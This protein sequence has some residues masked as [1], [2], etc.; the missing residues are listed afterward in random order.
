MTATEVEAEVE[1]EIEAGRRRYDK[2]LEV[3]THIN[4]CIF[5][6]VL[7]LVFFYIICV[8]TETATET[9]SCAFLLIACAASSSL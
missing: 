8:A 4:F 5:R 9:E 7:F 2:F 6:L 3:V 1:V